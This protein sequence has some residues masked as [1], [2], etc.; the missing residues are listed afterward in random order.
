G[1]GVADG[2]TRAAVRPDTAN[3]RHDG[4]RRRRPGSFA[5][6]YDAARGTYEAR[7][8]GRAKHPVRTA[9]VCD[10]S[11][12]DFEGVKDASTEWHSGKK[13]VHDVFESLVVPALS[14]NPL[15]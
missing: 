12:G 15:I 11:W 1:C 13:A 14:P 2:G 7:V 4:V 6:G 5:A 9:S 10:G 8:D 3:R